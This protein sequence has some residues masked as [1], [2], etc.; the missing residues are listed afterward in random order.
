[1][2]SITVSRFLNEEVV[3]FASYSTLR[4]I[5][6]L[7]DG[8]KNAGRKVIY[9]MANRPNKETKLSIL[10]GLIMTDTEYLHGDISGSIVTLA[11]NYVGSNNIPLLTREGNFGTRFTPEA[12]AIRYIFTNKESYFNDVFN[13]EDNNILISQEFEGTVIEP[14][15]FVPSIPLILVN[16]SEGIATGFAQKILPRN[17]NTIKEYINNYLEGKPLPELTPYY[18]GFNGAIKP[19][20]NTNQWVIGGVYEK[21][22]LTRVL[23]TELPVGYTLSSYT[24][25]LDD[26]EDKKI[27]KSYSDLSENDMFKFEISMDNNTIANN[28]DGIGGILK[29]N[30]TVTENFTVM[31]ENNRVVDYNSPE[32]VINH[33][34]RIKLE[35]LDKRKSYLINKINNDLLL[36]ASKYLFVKGVTENTIIVSKMKK[37]EIISQLNLPENDRIITYEESYDYLLKMPIYS[38][39]SEKL[40]ELLNKIKNLQV[41]LKTIKETHINDTWV[42]E[43]N[44][45]KG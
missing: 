13:P 35:Y 34:I 4:A 33:Y 38:L 40:E 26:L 29:L 36:L 21:R 25:I 1:M 37:D 20:E 22:H 6:S 16:G 44:I 18:N 39:T 43:L 23:V 8:Q 27:I 9:S 19:G 28:F 3:D 2:S 45:I 15:F 12:S 7:I 24:K 11:Q 31:D 41:E 5:G 14:R 42:K 17:L 10:A 32:E 30:K